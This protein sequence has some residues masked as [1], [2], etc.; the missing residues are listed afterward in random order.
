MHEKVDFLHRTSG[1]SQMSRRQ[2]TVTVACYTVKLRIFSY[3][4]ASVEVIRYGET[5]AKW[6]LSPHSWRTFSFSNAMTAA[7]FREYGVRVVAQGDACDITGIN[8]N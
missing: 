3:F 7:S 1:T 2:M 4:A 8:A 6:R 5:L